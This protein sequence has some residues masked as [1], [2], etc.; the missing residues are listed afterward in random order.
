MGV[1]MRRLIAAL[2]IYRLPS[3]P[4]GG[5]SEPPW[6]AYA[7]AACSDQE[8][9]RGVLCVGE[10][11]EHILETRGELVEEPVAAS[12]GQPHFPASSR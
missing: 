7:C 1:C 9:L 6:R 4:A 11:T 2:S 12:T 8:G 5:D 3:R 10:R